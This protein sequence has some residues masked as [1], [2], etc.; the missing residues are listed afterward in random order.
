MKKFLIILI[1]IICFT[2]CGNNAY[3]LKQ[4]AD[5][6]LILL[7]ISGSMQEPITTKQGKEPRF[8]L[9]KRL[10]K[11]ILRKYNSSDNIG[12]RLIG[13]SSEK[14]IKKIEAQREKNTKCHHCNKQNVEDPLILLFGFFTNG[15][16]FLC[17]DSDLIV[18]ISKRSLRRIYDVLYHIKPDGAST[19]IEYTL[20]QAI[21]ND[22]AKFPI[23]LKK[24]IILLTDG[25][26][27]C[28][29]DPCKYI[30]KLTETRNDIVIDVVSLQVENKNNLY[31]C[32]VKPTGGNVYTLVNFKI[33]A[34]PI[35]TSCPD[36]EYDYTNPK[37]SFDNSSKNIK[38]DTY[39]LEF[40]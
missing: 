2:Y 38:Y 9:A 32:I 29:G 15:M 35:T 11:E 27:S 12:L 5:V 6:T 40:N 23:N 24:H 37:K 18:P 30:Q 3:A 19:P 1:S 25:Y 17:N 31:N 33:D 39:L 7:D 28:G 34:K 10:L 22:F 8:F 4:K 36:C 14:A 26:E 16:N 21:E 20:Q 13:V